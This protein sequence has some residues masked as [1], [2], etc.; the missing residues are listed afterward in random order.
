MRRLCLYLCALGL[1]S[2]S[3]PSSAQIAFMYA[4]RDCSGQAIAN[5]GPANSPGCINLPLGQGLFFGT[6]F[7][8]CNENSTQATVSVYGDGVCGSQLF[9]D[10]VE[11]SA[12]LTLTNTTSIIVSC[13][14]AGVSTALSSVVLAVTAAAVVTLTLSRKDA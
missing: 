10:E 7:V 1:L 2:L 8:S 13:S 4:S 14:A 12:C 3:L 9:T 5:G 11:P 6:A